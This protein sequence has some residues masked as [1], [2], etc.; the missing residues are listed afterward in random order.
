MITLLTDIS[1]LAPVTDSIHRVPRLAELVRVQEADG[2]PDTPP[3]FIVDARGIVVPLCWDQRTVPFLRPSP[4]PFCSET[5]LG[6]VFDALGNE[7]Q[8]QSYLTEESTLGMELANRQCLQDHRPVSTF[9]AQSLEKKRTEENAYRYDHNIALLQQYGLWPVAVTLDDVRSRF[10]QALAAAPDD[11]H[12]A[13]TLK[14]YATLL[15][16]A[17]QLAE[18][19]TLLGEHIPRAL[20]EEA[21]YALQSLLIST[22]MTQL[23]V[24][25]DP[26]RLNELKGPVVGYA[27]VLRA[28]AT[29]HR[30]RAAAD[31]CLGGC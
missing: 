10:Q 4:L 5:L 3:D 17:Q 11:E 21:R 8:A 29:D 12:Y 14:Q 13:F 7:E 2:T 22:G 31:R 18:A 20:S 25:Y 9:L 23:A 28:A 16:D 26:V 15:I 19:E 30:G 27:F 1:H 24:P 6:L